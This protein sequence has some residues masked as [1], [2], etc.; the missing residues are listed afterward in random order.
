MLRASHMNINHFW[1]TSMRLDMF[2]MLILCQ[3][4]HNLGKAGNDIVSLHRLKVLIA[5][6][7]N[8]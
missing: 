6:S 2:R 4:D 1:K 5:K 7:F 8:I 3:K